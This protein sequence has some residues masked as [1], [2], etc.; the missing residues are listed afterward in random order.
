MLI[1]SFSIQTFRRPTSR[2]PPVRTTSAPQY[3]RRTPSMVWNMYDGCIFFSSYFPP[4]GH[5]LLRSNHQMIFMFLLLMPCWIFPFL[6]LS[7]AS[8][9][10]L[11]LAISVAMSHARSISTYDRF[12][13]PLHHYAF[14][15]SG[16]WN[17]FKMLFL[18]RWNI[19]ILSSA[20]WGFSPFLSFHYLPRNPLGSWSYPSPYL[21]P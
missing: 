17:C 12:Q 5:L 20:G 16:Y 3:Q 7:T 10:R 2:P 13:A 8:L 15:R 21:D 4:D 19:I 1:S 11:K 18:L 14:F 9:L 6:T